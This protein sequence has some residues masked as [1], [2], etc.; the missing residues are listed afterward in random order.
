[1]KGYGGA[2]DRPYT[3][4]KNPTK[5]SFGWWMDSEN[6]E[7]GFI[8]HNSKQLP[9]LHEQTKNQRNSTFVAQYQCQSKGCI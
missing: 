7:I 8:A 4:D 6:I 2:I 3:S 5:F 9:K 1:M